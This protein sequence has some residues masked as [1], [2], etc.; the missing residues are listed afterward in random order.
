MNSLVGRLGTWPFENTKKS[1][2]PHSQE[3]SLVPIVFQSFAYSRSGQGEVLFFTLPKQ[4]WRPVSWFS[5]RQQNP[6]LRTKIQNNKEQASETLE[7]L[8]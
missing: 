3:I 7:R 1:P 2:L 6:I 4:T 5:S 8:L